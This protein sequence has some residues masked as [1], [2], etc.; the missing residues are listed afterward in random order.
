[1]VIRCIIAI[2][3]ATGATMLDTKSLGQVL[4]MVYIHL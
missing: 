1:M 3:N 2:I 4:E